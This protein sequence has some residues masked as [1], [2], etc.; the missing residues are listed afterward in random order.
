M[1]ETESSMNT[2]K[3]DGGW[4]ERSLLAIVIVLQLAILYQYW[5]V[6]QAQSEHEVVMSSIDPLDRFKAEGMF[7]DDMRSPM[8]M[9]VFDELFR[10]ASRHARLF[11]HDPAWGRLSTVPGMDM[12]DAG[13]S[14]QLIF[15]LPNPDPQQVQ[16]RLDGNVLKIW[17]VCDR[18]TSS[19]G[20][21]VYQRQ[22]LLPAAMLRDERPVVDWTNGMLRVRV[23]KY[24]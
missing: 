19:V 21:Q 4:I 18:G 23:A 6:R 17:A 9:D 15:S 14:Y 12:R 24:D 10:A 8:A 5:Q 16:V 11:E 1:K 13:H 20:R 2:R 22:V 3:D 7:W